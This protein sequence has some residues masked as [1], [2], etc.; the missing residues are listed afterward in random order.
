MNTQ[1][2]TLPGIT[3]VQN[4]SRL[5]PAEYFEIY[6]PQN[7]HIY[8]AIVKIAEGYKARGSQYLSMQYVFGI[9]RH[10]GALQ[11]NGK[12]YKLPNQLT[13]QYT[14]HLIADRPDLA[15]MFRT[16]PLSSV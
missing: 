3:P 16:K 8:E 12:P 4:S 9:M 11:T 13:S 5:T 14:R 7:P 6:H 10:E 15:P 1:Q 2:L